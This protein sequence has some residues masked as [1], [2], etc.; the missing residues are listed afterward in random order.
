MR[1]IAG[2]WL[3]IDDTF[4]KHWKAGAITPM[5]EVLQINP[6]GRV[7]DRVMNFWAGS[8]RACLENK[9]CSDV[10]QIAV[11]RVRVSGDKLNFTNVVASNARP[12]HAGRRSAG[13]Q[14][15]DHRFGE[16]D[17][18]ARWRTPGAAH[19]PADRPHPGPRRSRPAAPASRRHAA[20]RLD[21]ERP[22]ALLPRQRHGARQGI[23]A[24]ADRP[25][26]ERARLPR[27]L[28]QS[29][30]L[31]QRDQLVDRH[32]GDRR[33]Q[34]GAP[35]ASL[36][37]ARGDAGAVLRGRAA[38]AVDRGPR[39]S[40]RRADLY[41]PP[42]PHHDRARRLGRR[43]GAGEVARRRGRGRGSSPRQD[44]PR[45]GQCRISAAQ[46]RANTAAAE[47]QQ[48]RDA[49][50][51]QAEAAKKA[52]DSAAEAEATASARQNA[53]AA[54][55]AAYEA[56]RRAATEQQQKVD[57]HQ[58]QCRRI[59]GE[60]RS[61]GA[62]G[63]RRA[64]EDRRPPRPPP[65]AAEEGRGRERHCPS[66]SAS[67]TRPRPTPRPSSRNI[68]PPRPRPTASSR[69]AT[70]MPRPRANSRQP[71]RPAKERRRSGDVAEPHRRRG[72]ATLATRARQPIR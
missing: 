30:D 14:G 71:R 58:P 36:G 45:R 3:A 38:P 55:Q 54:A 70:S 28:S 62:S 29:R 35:Q 53:A 16:L 17:R 1:D 10:P 11:A 42:R 59:A 63:G 12:R 23:R 69:P 32:A 72:P 61:R 4:P 22:L 50:D 40:Q 44:R 49:A 13:A 39:A 43:C 27:P 24:A 6:D 7:T 64:A 26:R 25:R 33:D 18:A 56:A 67:S 15:G 20:R 57:A 8:H 60:G 48:A 47:L 51:A 2:W 41:R 19:R 68:S 65:R 46:A 31:C 34:R 66:S 5:E 9:V 52:A 21:A 37:R